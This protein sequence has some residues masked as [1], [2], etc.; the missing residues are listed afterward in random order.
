MENRSNS[1]IHDVDA[2]LRSKAASLPQWIVSAPTETQE[3][4]SSRTWKIRTP[5]GTH[6]FVVDEDAVEDGINV[7]QLE[8]QMARYRWPS[9]GAYH[10]GKRYLITHEEGALVVRGNG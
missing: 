2:W 9:D 4:G 10:R 3:P 1:S 8:H 7:A 5:E 6:S